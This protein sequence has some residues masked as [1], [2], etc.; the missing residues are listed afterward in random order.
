MK[1]ELD[2]F[3][4]ETE[5]WLQD[6]PRRKRWPTDLDFEETALLIIDMQNYFLSRENHAYLPIGREI[7]ENV[8]SMI[9]LFHGND[10]KMIYTRTVQ[11]PG[12]EGVMGEWWNDVIREGEEAKIHPKIEV[13]GKKITKPRYSSFYRTDLDEMLEG[14]KN[15]VITGVMTNLCCSTTARDAFVRDFR[16][17]FTADGTATSDLETHFATLHSL[18]NGIAEVLQCGEVE[19]RLQ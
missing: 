1:E 19:E 16:V 10:A 5:S 7:I 2:S 9:D 17:L 12:D 15:V 18:S 8:N 4:E 11:E 3:Q 6:K 13:K 14:I